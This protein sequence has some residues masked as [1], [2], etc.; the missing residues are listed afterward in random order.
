MLGFMYIA[1]ELL[2]FLVQGSEID[3]IRALGP[4]LI[5]GH[6]DH[7]QVSCITFLNV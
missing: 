2:R 7:F 1:A 5:A 6:Q 3:G 4:D